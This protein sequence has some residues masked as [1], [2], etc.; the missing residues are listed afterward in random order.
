MS[1]LHTLSASAQ[2]A[3]RLRADVEKGHWRGLMPGVNFLAVELG[4]SRKTVEAALRQLEQEG[5]L[6]GQ[7]AGRKRRIVPA[8]RRT[9]R[10]MR[11]GILLHEPEDR[12][13][14]YILE[15]Q[16]GLADAG[17]TVIVA[18]RHLTELQMDL[19]RIA[20]LVRQAAADAWV[21]MSGS[22]EVLEW[23]SSR[24]VPAFALFG[25]REGLRIAAT[26]PDKG[27]AMTE[28]TR[29]LIALGHRRIA[30][31]TRRLRRLPEP[32]RLESAFLN[33][34]KAHGVT[35]GTYHLPDWEESMEGFQAL[36]RSLF[37]IT[38]PTALIVDEAPFFVAVQQFLAARGIR[39]PQQVSLICTDA[40][41]AFSWCLPPISHIR[42]ESKLLIRRIV[43]W[44]ATVS[45]GKRDVR[46]TRVPAQFDPGGTIGPAPYA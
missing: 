42:W 7:G 19:K 18:R 34:L 32:G 43:N 17:H 9:P 5:L 38:P 37:Q 45:R 28:A 13:L 35:P 29:R 46:Q 33:E 2:A 22:R 15:L 11:V 27:P 21:V 26:G 39:V 20:R 3:A 16:H 14:E 24:P 1:L 6:Q 10:P 8:K 36:L 31:L 44:A 12:H 23:F 40:S 30:L 25:R 4:V 41:S